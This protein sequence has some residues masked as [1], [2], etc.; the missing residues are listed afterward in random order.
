[1]DTRNNRTT[2]TLED[3]GSGAISTDS[4]SPDADTNVYNTVNGQSYG[5]DAMEQM[6]HDPTTG[7]Y[8]AYDYLGRLIE[9]AD[10]DAFEN[11]LKRYRYDVHS[12]MRVEETN[13]DIGTYANIDT[14]FY[15][16]FPNDPGASGS[17]GGGNPGIIYAHEE[18]ADAGDTWQRTVEYTLGVGITGSMSGS[19]SNPWVATGLPG[20]SGNNKAVV[21]VELISHGSINVPT[22]V[23]QYRSENQQRSLL[24]TTNEFGDRHAEIDYN[25]YGGA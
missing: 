16:C 25:E 24:G 20:G 15:G 18:R 13:A 3:D 4:Y 11:P 19:A 5:F 12:R 14:V 21:L 7:L 9:E 23:W 8:K 10:N 1:M 2:V 22:Y 17:C 6:T